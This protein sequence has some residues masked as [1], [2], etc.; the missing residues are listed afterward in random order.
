MAVL[1]QKEE[2]DAF[3][4][5]LKKY[6]SDDNDYNAVVNCLQKL[7][8]DYDTNSYYFN[9]ITEKIV[10]LHWET[11]S[12]EM[13]EIVKNLINKV[14]GLNYDKEI[15]KIAFAAYYSLS[16]IYKKN[17]NIEELN[18]LL[19]DAY[20]LTLKRF[21]L[22][23]EVRSRYHKRI[24]DYKNALKSDFQAINVLAN[25]GIENPAVYVSYAST[26]AM[27]CESGN[28]YTLN[29]NEIEKA[30]H[31]IDK[32]IDF[33]P[34]Y[35][36]YHFIKGKLIYYKNK[37]NLNFDEFEKSC[38][39]AKECIRK[40][41]ACLNADNYHYIADYDL[42]E[43]FVT[44]IDTSI[45]ERRENKDTS[46]A[47]R[48]LSKAEIRKIKDDILKSNKAQEC[49]P[50]CPKL[51]TGQKY[52]F[53]SYCTDDYKS[54]YCDLVELYANKIP[55]DYDE[56]LIHGKGWEAQV[57]EK[58][59]NDDCVGVLFYLSSK[60][61]LSDSIEKEIEMVTQ[62]FNSSN[63]FKEHCFWINLESG[64]TPFK[65]LLKAIQENDINSL[66]AKNVNVK[67]LMT[68]LDTFDDGSV[69]S[70]KDVE[71]DSNSHFKEFVR[72]IKDKFKVMFENEESK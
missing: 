26:V 22:I 13:P 25:H 48:N 34:S 20:F 50:E 67:R 54:V 56:A 64:Y 19:G 47:F 45:A 49:R 66:L 11:V 21:P 43:D 2:A 51:K 5:T 59:N 55:F 53:I 6:F 30:L 41:E 10:E 68:Y 24:G 70:E 36:K 31:Y 35:P 27:V 32:A 18:K 58:I 9:Y 69:F 60:T 37:N 16:L 52:I 38:K 14:E 44:L 15:A 29:D 46:E 1:F 40:A 7:V 62:K 71:P 3:V 61:V 57:K 23:F 39:T 12:K 4:D 33:N 28:T 8:E 42:Y 65:L 63:E 72:S 17:N